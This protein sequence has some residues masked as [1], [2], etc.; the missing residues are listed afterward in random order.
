MEKPARERRVRPNARSRDQALEGLNFTPHEFQTPPSSDHIQGHWP[1]QG[2]MS[3]DF[4]AGYLSGAIGI[5]IGNPLDILKVRLQAGSIN[6][7]TVEANA[8][9]NARL[10]LLR[11]IC[12]LIALE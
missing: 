10:S 3:A 12:I 4:W 2:R 11:G 6:S 7:F 8:I 1:S 9:A 5:I